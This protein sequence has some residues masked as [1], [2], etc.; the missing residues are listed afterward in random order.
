MESVPIME[1]VPSVPSVSDRLRYKPFGYKQYT[2]T[3]TGQQVITPSLKT[4]GNPRQITLEEGEEDPPLS[5]EDKTEEDPP[6]SEEDKTEEDKK[7]HIETLVNKVNLTTRA[8]D[9]YLREYSIINKTA[10]QMEAGGKK[11]RRKRHRRRHRR[12]TKKY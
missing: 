1:S 3:K 2:G 10:T 5:E 4:L 9:H 7:K 11:S 6:L 8:L 12:R